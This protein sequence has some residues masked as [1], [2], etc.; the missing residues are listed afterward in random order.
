MIVTFQEIYNEILT[1]MNLTE[2][3]VEANILNSIKLRINQIQDFLFYR[4]NY[5]WRKQP[6]YFTSRPIEQTGTVTVTQGS[7]TV[8]GSGTSWTD[9]IKYGH[10]IVNG[11]AYKIDPHATVTSTS[12]KLVSE[13]PDASGSSLS[14]KIIESTKLVDPN[15]SSIVN[16]F[17]EGSEKKVT[18]ANRL[19]LT[20]VDTG[21]PLEFA[22]GGISNFSYYSTGTV[23]VTQDSNAVVGVGTTFTSD[24]EGMPFRVNDF[25][26]LY[27]IAEVQDSTNLTLKETYQGST[28]SGKSYKIAPE[29]SLLLQSRPVADTRYFVEV[30]ALIKS[31]R[32]VRP[33]DISLLPDH[34]PLLWGSIWYAFDTAT[35]KN[36]VKTNMAKSNFKDA[37]KLFDEQYHVVSN[38]KWQSEYEMRLRR[39]GTARFNPLED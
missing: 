22:L 6:F 12:L 18:N 17:I 5:E 39:A 21:E 26:I 36:P 13:Y 2:E 16:I 7:R 3:T 10:I 35:E 28:A 27:T 25:P 20:R 4:K 9:I 1:Q 23:S 31:K 38:M 30:E 14:Y 33:T 19:T 34:A 15:I 8:T 37:L 24:M 29:G 32:L 11:K